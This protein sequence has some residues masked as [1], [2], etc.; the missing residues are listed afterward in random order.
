MKFISDS[1]KLSIQSTKYWRQVFNSN[2]M[3]ASEVEMQFQQDNNK[4]K[5]M[6]AD[7][8]TPNGDPSRYGN[9]VHQIKGDGS[10]RN[11]LEITL[12]PRRIYSFV[13]MFA[14]Y[15]HLAEAME[16]GQP[17]IHPRASWHNH[18][19][20]QN[21]GAN[22]LEFEV[23][24][25]VISNI[26]TLF[27]HFIPGLCYITAT[28]PESQFGA[29]TRYSYFRNKSIQRFNARGHLK[30]EIVAMR[31][32]RYESVNL[33]RLQIEERTLGT[34]VFHMELRF[35][36]ANLFPV[37]QAGFNFIIKALILKA[38]ELSRFGKIDSD[39]DEDTAIAY[40]FINEHH[41]D[42][43]DEDD[44]D[45]DLDDPETICATRLSDMDS[46]VTAKA[47]KNAHDL[48]NLL[49]STL[50]SLEPGSSEV[51]LRMCK[52]PIFK[53]FKSLDTTDIYEVNDYLNE[54]ALQLYSPMEVDTEELEMLIT[55]GDIKGATAEEWKQNCGLAPEC[56]IDVMLEELN[57]F[58][59]V[60]FVKDSYVFV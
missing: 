60:E 48:Y 4:V 38:I 22:A 6:L 57:K 20:V 59:K 24:E 41:H 19:V 18:V 49:R 26:I 13:Q 33:Q 35:P 12:P 55:M 56:G 39:L 14:G 44:E 31:D 34:S 2:L 21:Y 36:D 25:T 15:N 30:R 58:R 28:L 52:E 51:M 54:W 3:F 10:L 47:E 7:A 45:E 9:G 5:R 8:L 11:G 23:P 53:I 46:N 40:D 1:K 16:E 43:D 27:K 42:E 32:S 37:Y 50:E 17:Y 29:V